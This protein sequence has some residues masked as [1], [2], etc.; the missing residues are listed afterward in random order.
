[1]PTDF[2]EASK[3]ALPYAVA[4]ASQFGASITVVHVVPTTLPAELSHLGLVLEE[5]RP[6]IAN[7]QNQLRSKTSLAEAILMNR[8]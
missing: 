4:L 2:S 6:R 8:R 1:V 3:Q 5:K 7:A